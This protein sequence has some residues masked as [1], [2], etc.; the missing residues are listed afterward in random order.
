MF[1]QHYRIA[2]AM[3]SAL[4]NGNYYIDSSAIA[5]GDRI[6]GTSSDFVFTSGV[7][8]S[9]NLDITPD[10]NSGVLIDVSEILEIVNSVWSSV[11][12]AARLIL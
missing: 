5:A 8:L 7:L 1:I 3:L 9:F 12:A 2:S 11:E 10:E 4:N 6:S